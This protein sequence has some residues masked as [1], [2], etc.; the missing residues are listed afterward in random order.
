M[1]VPRRE[2]QNGHRGPH[3]CHVFPALGRDGGRLIKRFANGDAS[4]QEAPWRV[5]SVSW[6][7]PS[8]AP[9]ASTNPKPQAVNSFQ[10]AAS[11]TPRH[12]GSLCK[13]HAAS[14]A[15]SKNIYEARLGLPSLGTATGAL[16]ARNRPHSPE[17]A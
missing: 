1:P 14:V 4:E 5:G 8:T 17:D 16:A 12:L 7:F 3:V 9:S 6:R 10:K 15:C 11:N 13:G 2:G